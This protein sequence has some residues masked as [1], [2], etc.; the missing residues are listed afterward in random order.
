[1]F[2]PLAFTIA[3]ALVGS[4]V[5]SLTLVPV[6]STFLSQGQALRARHLA[7]GARQ[8]ALPAGPALVPRSAGRCPWL[9]ALVGLVVSGFLFTRLGREFL[10]PLDEGAIGLQTFRLPSVSLSTS[11]QNGAGGRERPALI[12]RDHHRGVE[13][14]SRRHRVGP[15]GPRGQRRDRQPTAAVG[16]EDREDARGT[17]REDPR[18]PRRDPGHVLQLLAAHPAARGR[19]GLGRQGSDRRSRSS[20]TTSTSC[21]RRARRSSASSGRFAERPT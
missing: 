4:L 1:M 2:A 12:P 20:A 16:V 10:P 21:E 13:D 19:A 6:A 11:Q 8:A 15:D 9:L 7:G 17:G 14:R 3:A 5:L 18:A